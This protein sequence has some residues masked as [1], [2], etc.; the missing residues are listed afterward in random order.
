MDPSL[1]LRAPDIGDAP[2]LLAFELANRAYFESWINARDP[3]YYSL[4]G[5]RAAIDAAMQARAADRGYQYLAIDD[6]RIVGRVNLTN[7][8]R[9]YYNAAELG[10]RV[11]EHEGGKGVASCA[12][13]LCL[14]EAFGPLALWRVEATARPANAA[15]IRVL[16]RSGFQA[17]GHS[18]R[19][20]RLHDEWF[21]LVHFE[22]HAD[23]AR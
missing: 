7:V 3:S 1:H 12:V 17:F 23:A 8:R 21:D 5:V 2:A 22:R 20:F 18:R 9:A 13:A 14:A 15:S 10:Y 19:C 6:S 16:E 4:G 11:G